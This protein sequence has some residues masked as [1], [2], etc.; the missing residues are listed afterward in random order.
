MEIKKIQ[1]LLFDFGAVLYQIDQTRT[2]SL[3]MEHMDS[4]SNLASLNLND[5]LQM[6]F[7][8]NYETGK[9]SSH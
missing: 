8:R 9:I 5:F 6:N 7:F 4:K 1:Y 2:L 3:Y